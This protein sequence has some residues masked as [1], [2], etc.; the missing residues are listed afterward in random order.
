MESFASRGVCL[1]ECQ[2]SRLRENEVV[3][4]GV[5]EAGGRMGSGGETGEEWVGKEGM[6]AG[7]KENVRHRG[8]WK[9]VRTKIKERQCYI[10]KV[11]SIHPRPC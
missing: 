7:G 8:R 4:S 6:K 5:K 1:H 9:E 3:G 2:H 10:N 11:T